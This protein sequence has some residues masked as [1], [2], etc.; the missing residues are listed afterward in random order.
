[1]KK[2]DVSIIVINYNTFDLTCQCLD[3][4]FKHTS[5]VSFEVILVDN[6]STEQDP[7]TFKVKY[8]S[9][10][11]IRSTSNVGFAKGNNMGIEKAQGEYILLFNSDAFMA[12][13]VPLALKKFMEAHLD[14]AA[15]T[16]RLEYP[17]GR[18][19]HNCQRF[20]SI[21]YT[22]FELFRLQK[23]LSHRIG[24]KVLFGPFFDYNSI[25][26]PDW[27][28]GTC[29]MFRKELLKKLPEGRLAD[30]FF[31]YGEDVQWCMEFKKLGYRV[32]FDSSI[33]V[34]HLLGKSGGKKD[35][36]MAK[37]MDSLMK[38]YYSAFH[39]KCIHFLNRL[40]VRN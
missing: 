23:F 34:I 28:W 11:L 37:N 29:F 19:Q 38:M 18:L 6:A 17:D 13:N 4:I 25:A 32:A 40:L 15:S 2:L 24:G 35:E 22:L 12:G 3:S 27:I 14:V 31:M 26:F 36:L 16:T 10:V 7:G 39:R 30:N 1:M 8:P 33:V 5:D 21:R 20:P 9:I